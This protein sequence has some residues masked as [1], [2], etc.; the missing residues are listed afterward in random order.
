MARPVL[1]VDSVRT[2]QLIISGEGDR[3]DSWKEELHEN[4]N[5]DEWRAVCLFAWGLGD[6]MGMVTQK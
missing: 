1:Y 5:I 6:G 3:T 4:G 2:I